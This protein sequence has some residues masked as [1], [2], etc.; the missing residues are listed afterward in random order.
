MTLSDVK[1]K[2]IEEGLNPDDYSILVNE[3]GFSVWKKEVAPKYVKSAE[4]I[5][6]DGDLKVLSELY[7]ELM[8][9]GE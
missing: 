2:L 1:T 8:K 3:D 7:Y 6:E 9:V 4:Q 5:S